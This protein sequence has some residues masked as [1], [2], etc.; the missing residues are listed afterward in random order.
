MTI[1]HKRY[2]HSVVLWRS[3]AWE[4]AQSVPVLRRNE[5]VFGVYSWER[6]N[7]GV[8]LRYVLIPSTRTF[9]CVVPSFGYAGG[10][11]IFVFSRFCFDRDLSFLEVMDTL[12]TLHVP[13]VCRGNVEEIASNGRFHVVPCVRQSAT[14]I[15]F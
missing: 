7:D 3:L 5:F 6:S 11:E 9:L 14:A 13:K 2:V 15:V 12:G 1:V 4:H 8:F 10:I